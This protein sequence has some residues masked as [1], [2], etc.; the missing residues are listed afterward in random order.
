MDMEAFASGDSWVH[1]L[2]P[3]VKIVFTLVFSVVVALN[4]NVH[5]TALSLSLPVLLIICAQLEARLVLARLA[6]V[7]GF[8]LFIWMFLPL[9]TE[10][11]TVYTLGPLSIQRE[12]LLQAALITLKSN[13]IILMVMALLGTSPI[14]TLVHAMSHLG[15]PDKLV[16]LF[17]FCFRY[18]HV[19]QAEYHRLH[20]AMKM[21]GFRPRTDMHTY[22]SYAYLVGMLLVRSFD[23]AQRILQAMKCRGFA[24]KFYILHHYEMKRSDY[25]FAGSSIAF[26]IVLL[27]V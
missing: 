3:R 18:I 11:E 10:G 2:D 21:R 20:N 25:A 19:I 26:G 9:T 6:I 12:G 16:H 13:S 14:F 17:F 1:H 7:N 4:N 8:I 22:R 5:V 15:I 24:G 23:R 27:A